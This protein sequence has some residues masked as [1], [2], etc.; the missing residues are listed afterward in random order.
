[1]SNFT[2]FM[3]GKSTANYS[4]YDDLLINFEATIGQSGITLDM[5]TIQYTSTGATSKQNIID[6]Y[7]C[8]IND[9]GL[10]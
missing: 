4:Y 2:N 3:S 5:G 10:I 1:V 7:S 8:T 9:G 6:N